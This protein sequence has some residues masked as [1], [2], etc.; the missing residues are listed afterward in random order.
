MREESKWDERNEAN[1][2]EEAKELRALQETLNP[3]TT[4]SGLQG[5]S[6]R[7]VLQWA[8]L[9]G[10]LLALFA[11]VDYFVR[12]KDEGTHAGAITSMEYN[13]TDL[14]ERRSNT[15]KASGRIAG[16]IVKIEEASTLACYEP[17]RGKSPQGI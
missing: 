1:R 7:R 8:A 9:L 16:K 3:R 5:C 12:A 4:L 10:L 11:V 6:L 17:C 2:V 13:N 14:L 15:R